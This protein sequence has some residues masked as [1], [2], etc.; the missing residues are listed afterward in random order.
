[1]ITQTPFSRHGLIRALACEF[2]W[3]NGVDGNR[4]TGYF[5]AVSFTFDSG[6]FNVA[7]AYS[8]GCCRSRS[9]ARHCST[10]SILAD[11][12]QAA[13]CVKHEAGPREWKFSGPVLC[14]F[15]LPCQ[16]LRPPIKTV[17]STIRI[18]QIMFY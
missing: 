2:T 5:R 1:M 18:R 10:F 13:F 12:P 9:D 14:R 4:H 16:I 7:A 17:G 6:L 3:L 15:V 8:A 11:S